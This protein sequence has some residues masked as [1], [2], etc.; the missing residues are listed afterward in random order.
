MLRLSYGQGFNNGSRSAR[1]WQRC[2]ESCPVA[3]LDQHSAEPL[4]RIATFHRVLPSGSVGTEP[5]LIAVLTRVDT[6]VQQI[7]MECQIISRERQLRW[8][9]WHLVE[10]IIVSPGAVVKQF[11]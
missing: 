7:V 4:I 6:P 2:R 11:Y 5:V 9:N 1:R 10:S 8:S 3:P